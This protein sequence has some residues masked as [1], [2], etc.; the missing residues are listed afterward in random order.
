[1]KLNRRKALTLA[2]SSALVAMPFVHRARA[3]DKILNVYNW[4]DYIGE[5]TIEDFQKATGIAVTYDTY[6][7]T[8]EMQAKMLAGS[9]GYDVV[10]MAGISLPRF[11]TAGIYQKID[12]SKLPN[13]KN[14]DPAIL[15]ILEG[16]D[17]GNQYAMP[18]MWGSVGFTYNVD[19]VKERLPAADLESLDTV[20]KPEN[21]QKLADCGISWLDEPTD[22][23][24]I[25]LDYLGKPRD[26]YAAADLDAVVEAFK[27][28][29]PTVR[30]FDSTNY[31]NALP[32]QELCAV[33]NWSGD[34]STAKARAEEAGVK[35]NLAY[36][37]PKTGAPAWFDLFCI[38]ADAKNVENAHTF[39]NYMMEAEVIAKCTNFTNYANANLASKAFVDPA[40]L[41]NPAVYPTDEVMKRL[42]TPKPLTEEQ[43]RALTETFNKMKSG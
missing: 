28:I 39:I 43:D 37:V 22:T 36:A 26:T 15:K 7:S 17:P 24:M 5:T 29:R 18:Y 34:Y 10:D 6:S 3:Q 35:I 12:K 14:L 13:W 16:F 11:V 19:M 27:A 32:N 20:L 4:A 40:V 31:L 23:I 42:W 1:M 8:D 41:A 2:G 38:P 25:L 30:T 33:N 9:T 21:A